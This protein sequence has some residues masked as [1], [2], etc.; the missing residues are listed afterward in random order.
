MK[1][2][3]KSE[4]K[5]LL[6][7]NLSRQV[8]QGHPW[9]YRDAIARVDGASG[10]ACEQVQVLD[11]KGKALA[12]AI[13]D[14][15]GSLALRVLSLNKKFNEAELYRRMNSAKSLR[16]HLQASKN[17][18]YRAI[19]GEGDLLPGLVLDVYNH[20]GVLQFDG[21]ACQ[22]FWQQFDLENI[23][24]VFEL[25]ALYEKPRGRTESSGVWIKE[26]SVPK[27]LVQV[28][29]N[30]LNFKV[31]IVHGQK[32]GFFL[33]QRN[34]RDYVKGISKGKKVLNLFSYTGG[35]S[36]AAGVGGAT[37]VA[38]VDIS[39][40]ALSLAEANWKL[41]ELPD[42]HKVVQSDVHEYLKKSTDQWDL[43]VVDPPTM[44]RSEGEKPAGIAK[45]QKIF[46]EAL[47]LAQQGTH[48]CFSSCSS[49]VS[50][51]DFLQIIK[52]SLSE[53]K[54]TGLILRVSGQ[55]EDHPVPSGLLEMRYLKFVHLIV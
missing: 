27:E 50:M 44:A 40:K 18:C 47:R 29:E 54:K 35:F 38:S 49:H 55:G 19:N 30:D 16:Q 22:E 7:R 6:R 11:P 37:H 24:T 1:Q 32:T 17:S 53:A 28:K 43:I 51:E 12:W 33:D 5:V 42:V 10:Q 23:I 14:P 20:C 39:P 45:Y 36:V 4:T 3:Y 34:N 8:K 25:D 48:L 15:K 21:S 13:F 2:S 9:I 46:V 26:S 52:E 41:N 31:D